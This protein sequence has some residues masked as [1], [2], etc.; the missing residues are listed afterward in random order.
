[1]RI[2]ASFG[3]ISF[4]YFYFVNSVFSLTAEE[5]IR[6]ADKLF[7]SNSSVAEIEMLVITP[8]WQRKLELKIWTKGMNKTLITILS[9]PKEKGVST[10]RIGR[11]MWNYFPKIEKTVKIPPSMMM[12]SWMGS[13][14]TND[15]LVK[16]STFIDDY[17]YSFLP[18]TSNY[19]AIKLI[20]KEGTAIVWSKIELKMDKKTLIPFEF[21]YF[22]EKNTPVK[23]L[24]MSNI[25]DFE[26]RTIPSILEMINL[27]EPDKKTVITYRNAKF[28]IEL[29][30]DTFTLRNLQRKH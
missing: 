6:K 3:I 25:K 15:D 28:D 29:P 12:N 9:P 8:N 20:P 16:E 10:L 21:I 5:L 27:K 22:D 23:K 14:F 30:A 17:S 2:Y 26:G 4:L 11:E 24:S 19:W 18:E 13:D 7:R 1:M